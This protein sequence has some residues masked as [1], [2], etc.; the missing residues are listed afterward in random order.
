MLLPHPPCY[1]LIV[2]SFFGQRC[3]EEDVK[4]S[5]EALQILTAMAS[6]ATLRYCLN[7]I[8]CADLLAKKRKSDTVDVDDLSR[9]YTYFLDEKRSVQ[10]LKE[11]QGNMIFNEEV[12]D[13]RMLVD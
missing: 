4:L 7:L 11:Q 2:D 3:Q 10:W 12:N 13:S 6:D 1:H 9:C 8:S 5:P